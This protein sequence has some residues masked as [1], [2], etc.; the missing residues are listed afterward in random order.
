MRELWFG[1]GRNTQKAKKIATVENEKEAMRVIDK[2]LAQYNVKSYYKNV[3][4]EDD[5]TLVVDYG[6]WSQFYYLMPEGQTLCEE[7]Q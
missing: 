1:Y 2:N 6:S 3:W 4:Q 5:G 7:G